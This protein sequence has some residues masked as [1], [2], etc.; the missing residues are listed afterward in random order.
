MPR[1]KIVEEVVVGIQ[2]ENQK[3]LKVLESKFREE[4]EAL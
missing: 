3:S 1:T 2:N 4:V